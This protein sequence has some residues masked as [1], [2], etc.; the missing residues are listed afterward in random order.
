MLGNKKNSFGGSACTTLI[1]RDTVIVGD[2][3]FAGSLD[4]E[5]LVQ[6]N[7]LAQP[8]QEAFVRVV[9][10]GRIEGEIRA[11]SV[12]INGEVEGDIHSTQRL[13]LAS[14]ARVQGDVFYTLI[15]MAVGAEVNGH[16]KHITDP[17]SESDTTL[18][19]AIK[20]AELG[21]ADVPTRGMVSGSAKS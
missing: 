11:P 13:E 9:D 6:G 8:G 15:E 5:G 16:L 19:P 3:H 1:S 10:S 17:A 21:K 18:P 7:I 4:V 2:I 12:V 20:I 14:K